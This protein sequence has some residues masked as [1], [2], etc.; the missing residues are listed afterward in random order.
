MARLY[1]KGVLVSIDKLSKVPPLDAPLDPNLFGDP[2]ELH[3][4]SDYS[5]G[6]YAGIGHRWQDLK[7]IDK[8]RQG[9][10]ALTKFTFGLADNMRWMPFTVRASCS[11]D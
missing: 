5:Q 6:Q 11:T 3:S 9:L 8:C 1:E 2:S 4:G 10:R 7:E